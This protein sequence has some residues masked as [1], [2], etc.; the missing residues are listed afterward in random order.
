MKL[1]QILKEYRRDVT[2]QAF[3]DR[4]L[5]ALVA[6]TLPEGLENEWRLVSM[7][8]KAHRYQEDTEYTFDVGGQTIPVNV[9]TAPDILK[10]YRQ[11]IID[12][13][14]QFIERRDPTRHKE[15]T[16]WMVRQWISDNVLL[17]DLNRQNL[18]GKFDI[19][20]RRNLLAPEYRDINR[21]K[22]YTD[23]EDVIGAYDMP[24]EKPQ[25]VDRGF[26][27]DQYEDNDVR[28]VRPYNEAAA[29][30]YGQGTKWCTA[31]KEF[32]QFHRYNETGELYILLPTHPKYKGEKYQMH[33][34][35]DQYMNERDEPVSPRY[36]FIDRFPNLYDFFMETSPQYIED[37]VFFTDPKTI[38]GILKAIKQEAMRYTN[39]AIDGE[40]LDQ[41][42]AFVLRGV[43]EQID[44]MNAENFISEMQEY[45]M[46]AKI[47]NIPDFI[48]DRVENELENINEYDNK[49]DGRIIAFISDIELKRAKTVDGKIKPDPEGQWHIF[50]NYRGRKGSFQFT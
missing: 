32:N 23:F 18:I 33:F 11:Q 34:V 36:L 30:Y 27:R 48:A 37:S 35:S 19:L 25:E 4:I 14:L 29:C 43:I 7:V 41:R 5:K 22:T 3:G 50:P 44:G 40:H 9:K 39:S 1:I 8:Y 21:F 24:E 2:S 10:R 26:Y 12:K 6:E 20:K 49:L 28:V 38:D 17:E 16:Q 42:S 45:G 31:G 13:I 47:Q 46:S 15:Y